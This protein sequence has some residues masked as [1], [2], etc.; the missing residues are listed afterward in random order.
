M[1]KYNHIDGAISFIVVGNQIKNKTK[2]TSK[3][4]IIT[5]TLTRPF[6]SRQFMYLYTKS[7]NTF[8]PVNRFFTSSHSDL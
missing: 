4:Q 7:N 1:E 8:T 6:M 5:Y 3:G 2:K